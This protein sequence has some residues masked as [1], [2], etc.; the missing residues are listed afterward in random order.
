MIEKGTLRTQNIKLTSKLRLLNQE[1]PELT[2]EHVQVA[3]DLVHK[4]DG[5]YTNQG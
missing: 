4:K 3:T 1:F 2:Q 5:K